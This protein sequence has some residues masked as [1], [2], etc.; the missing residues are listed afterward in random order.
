ME[1][2]HEK[3]LAWADEL[4]SFHLPKWEELPDLELYMD[5]V[6]TLIDKYLSPVIQSEKH[7]LLTAAM[8]NN[9]V[10][11]HIIP[12]PI[13]KK[14][15]RKHL[16]FLLAITSLK[17]VLTINEIRTGILFQGKQVGIRKAYDL[18]CCEQEEAIHFI[19][20]QIDGPIRL[21]KQATPLELIAVKAATRSF[22]E[23]LLAEKMIELEQQYLEKVE[24][25]E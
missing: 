11:L 22:A 21:E 2:I 14:Y 5:Q 1:Q 10:K 13:K 6:L 15:N 12:A 20:Q 9:Y 24:K 8:V 17:Q 18:F 16:A 3:L 23:K 19:K 4:Q 25:S 7:P